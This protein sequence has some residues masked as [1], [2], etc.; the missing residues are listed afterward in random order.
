[1]PGDDLAGD[2]LSSGV[3]ARHLAGGD[4]P[5]ELGARLRLIFRL[6]SP[7]AAPLEGVVGKE[8]SCQ[9]PSTGIR[10]G[11]HDAD[12]TSPSASAHDAHGQHDV[13]TARAGAGSQARSV[14]SARVIGSARH[15]ATNGLPDVTIELENARTPTIRSRDARCLRSRPRS[16]SAPAARRRARGQWRA[17][18]A[19]AWPNAHQ[20]PRSDLRAAASPGPGP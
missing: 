4:S 7:D 3:V 14:G 10:P 11:R 17:R 19:R 18:A 20:H 16:G 9:A 13:G 1:M 2:W 6:E 5:S 12:A 15:S 8:S